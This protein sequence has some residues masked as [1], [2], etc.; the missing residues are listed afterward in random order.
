MCPGHSGPGQECPSRLAICA[1][2]FMHKR[3]LPC[4]VGVPTKNRHRGRHGWASARPSLED[5]HRI[6]AGTD[7]ESQYL[8]DSAGIAGSLLGVENGNSCS[9]SRP[10]TR[11]HEDDAGAAVPASMRASGWAILLPN[12]LVASRS[13][14]VPVSNFRH[15]ALHQVSRRNVSMDVSGELDTRELRLEDPSKASIVRN[16]IDD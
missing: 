3:A 2:P 15:G 10:I 1:Y 16:H 4:H 7:A 9:R 11:N 6:R 14:F 13:S 12:T 5:A 8:W